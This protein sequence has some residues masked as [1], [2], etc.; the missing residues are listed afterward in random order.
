MSLRHFT[1]Q[2]GTLVLLSC[3]TELRWGAT[4]KGMGWGPM[5]AGWALRSGWAGL[6]GQS[7]GE[8]WWRGWGCATVLAFWPSWECS[9][10]NSSYFTLAHV[11]VFLDLPVNDEAHL[12]F[13]CPATAVVR[14]ERRCA[15]LPLTSLQDFMCFRDVYGMALF[16][17]KCMKF[18]DA[19]AVAAA[20][21]QPR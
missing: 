6:G 14:R 17:H 15:Q 1:V 9:I 11:F 13:S 10:W 19:A 20:R 21:Q 7:L 12:P 16:V 18:A 2:S 8:G 3:N 5:A 4:D